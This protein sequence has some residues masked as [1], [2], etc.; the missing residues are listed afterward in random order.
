[1]KNKAFTLIEL[2]VVVLIIGILAAIAVPKY[3][4]AVYKSQYS[5]MKELANAIKNAQEL[6][7]LSHN[8]YAATLPELD[9]SLGDST[10]NKQ[11][12]PWGFCKSTKST[13]SHTYCRNTQ[14]GMEYQIY[15][16]NLTDNSWAE[17]RQCVAIANQDLSSV[18]NRLCREETGQ[19]NPDSSFSSANYTVWNYK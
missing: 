6:Y 5:T 15:Y 12:Y 8:E 4:L 3:Q 2:L 10:T 9:I 16:A 11:E 14:I 13:N 18:Q 1:M 17:L 19:D 7:Y